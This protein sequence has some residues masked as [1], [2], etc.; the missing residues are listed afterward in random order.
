MNNHHPS[1]KNILERTRAERRVALSPA[2]CA[3]L[4]R[5]YEIPVPPQALA[6]SAADAVKVAAEIG[7]P[8]AM[9][10][11]SAEIQHK[12]EVGGVAL[13]LGDASAVE[14]SFKSLLARAKG[15]RPGARL[16]GVLVQKMVPG[17]IE[18]IV[19]ASTDPSFGKLVAF[20]VGGVMVETLSDIAFRLAPVTMPEARSMLDGIRSKEVL[21]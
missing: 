4:C 10:I 14:A 1:V 7:Y 19:G 2:D 21:N 9:K 11:S 17:G 15:L 5:A 8:V 16:E 13:N 12:T 6:S 18:L 20:G 3:E